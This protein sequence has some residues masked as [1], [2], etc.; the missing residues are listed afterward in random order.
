MDV[1]KLKNVEIDAPVCPYLNVAVYIVQKCNFNDEFLVEHM[2][3]PLA[4]LDGKPLSFFD[5]YMG[6]RKESTVKIAVAKAMGRTVYLI[7]DKE[8]ARSSFK[9]DILGYDT[10]Y[11]ENNDE[12]TLISVHLSLTSQKY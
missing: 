8:G 1:L 10:R 5:P 11:T 2:Q 6:R 7:E 9:I 12:R 3:I 4:E